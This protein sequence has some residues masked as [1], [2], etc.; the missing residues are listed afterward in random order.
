MKTA[1]KSIKYQNHF[2]TAVL[3][4]ALLVVSMLISPAVYAKDNTGKSQSAEITAAESPDG[5]D[6]EE[7]EENEPQTAIS[8]FL[9]SGYTPFVII[10]LI[11]IVVTVV[12][13]KINKNKEE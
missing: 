3:L 4:T 5:E 6:T 1:Y 8:V 13:D 9:T 10:T 12:R 11:M 2:T 7:A